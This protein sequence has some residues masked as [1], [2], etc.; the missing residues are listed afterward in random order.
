M[1]NLEYRPNTRLAAVYFNG[2]NANLLRI[3][4][5]VTLADLKNQLYEINNWLRFRDQRRVTDVEYY[6]PSGTTSE[7]TLLFT[8][9]KL[10]NNG[11]VRTMFSVFS[12]YRTNVPIELDASLVRYVEDIMSNLIR[13]RT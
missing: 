9:V 11:D 8:N 12:R 5:N 13:P 10:R 1:E 4:V 6:C 2:G 7:G 3:H